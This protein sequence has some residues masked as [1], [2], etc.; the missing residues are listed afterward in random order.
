MKLHE[1]REQ[2]YLFADYGPDF[3]KVN[4]QILR[5]NL[6]L[7]PDRIDTDW[8]ARDFDS[9]E[10]AHFEYILTFQPEL[11][12]LGTGTQLRFPHPRLLAPLSRQ[13]IGVDVMDLGAACRTYNILMSEGRRVVAAMLLL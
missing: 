2:G 3:L 5:Q 13:G 1:Q 6:L 12:L 7:S 9:L 4:D 10:A 8:P 11:V